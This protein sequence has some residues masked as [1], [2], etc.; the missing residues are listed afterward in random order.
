MVTAAA[1]AAAAAGSAVQLAVNLKSSKSRD[2]SAVVESESLS[3]PVSR[4]A[5][6]TDDGDRGLPHSASAVNAVM[7][8][9][10]FVKSALTRPLCDRQISIVNLD[11][12]RSSSS[13]SDCIRSDLN[14]A[15]LHDLGCSSVSAGIVVD[16][17]LNA[18]SALSPLTS[19]AQSYSLSEQVPSVPYSRQ[20][21]EYP[22]H[23]V[24]RVRED[25]S[26][27]SNGYDDVNPKGLPSD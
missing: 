8:A 25:L 24:T 7:N 1:T 16:A 19:L 21:G 6:V 12:N 13:E 14:K 5:A 11:R 9:T 3:H 23:A 15:D 18:S 4:N 22:P 20:Q 10:E 26:P 2:D 17:P 27:P